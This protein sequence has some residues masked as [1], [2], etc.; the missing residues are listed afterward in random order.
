MNRE[1]QTAFALNLDV[2]CGVAKNRYLRTM[3]MLDDRCQTSFFNPIQKI[4]SV[5]SHILVSWQ[6]YDQV[7]F[8]HN[9]QR[10][11]VTVLQN[12]FQFLQAHPFVYKAINWHELGDVKTRKFTGFKAVVDALVQRIKSLPGFDEKEFREDY[13]AP[14]LKL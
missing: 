1:K 10:Q 5:F 12:I 4:D 6:D 13:V 9:L 8:D 14:L 3:L 7:A 2:N 11:M